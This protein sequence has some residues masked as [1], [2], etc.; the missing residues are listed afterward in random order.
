MTPSDNRT[1]ILAVEII[2]N[3][4]LKHDSKDSLI[5]TCQLLWP[6][7]DTNPNNSK[8]QIVAAFIKAMPKDRPSL[9]N[10]TQCLMD[11]RGT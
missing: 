7:F 3:S 2:K 10:M 4:L 6:E 5:M 11:A 8:K 9:I 1:I